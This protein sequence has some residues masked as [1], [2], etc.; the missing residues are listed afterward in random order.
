MKKSIKSF[1]SRGAIQSSIVK[2]VVDRRFSLLRK[3]GVFFQDGKITSNVSVGTDL[4]RKIING[5]T[6]KIE[7][8]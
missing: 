1:Q 7:R 2:N 3:G 4:E 5:D 8:L 6:V